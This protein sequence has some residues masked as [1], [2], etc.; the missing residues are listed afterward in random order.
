M[1]ARTDTPNAPWELVE[2]DS[3]RFARVR[4]LETV[5]ARIEAGMRDCGQEPPEPLEDD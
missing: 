1:L 2:G 4:V 3:K 5:I